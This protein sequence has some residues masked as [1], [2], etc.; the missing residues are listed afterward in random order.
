M[1]L[2]AT[3]KR[4]R[5]D[6][7]G[8]FSSFIQQ[9]STSER[10]DR[11]STPRPHSNKK[12]TQS[13]QISK[14]SHRLQDIAIADNAKAH[15]GNV[16]NKV[17]NN[18]GISYEQNAEDKRWEEFLN[19]LRF[20]SMG[21]RFDAITPAHFDTCQ[22]IF[23]KAEFLRWRN[24]ASGKSRQSILWLKGKPGAGKS[25]LMKCILEHIR[26]SM[27]GYEP[28]SFFFNARGDR[29]ERSVEGMYRSMLCE[30]LEK[31]PHLRTMITIPRAWG[32]GQTLTVESLRTLF[33]QAVLGLKHEQII[34][35]MDALDEGDE[36]EVRSMIEFVTALAK[37]AK[38]QDTPFEICFASRHYP[39][40]SASG[41]EE[42]IV[43]R[44]AEHAK[45]IAQYVRSNLHMD[46]GTR[47]D[48]F[49]HRIEQTAEGVFMWAVLIV[50]MLNRESD[51]G[52]SNSDLMAT[53][54]ETPTDLYEVL[55]SIFQSG[56]SDKN[57]LPVLVWVFTRR[58]LP[59]PLRVEELYFGVQ[60][61][62][63]RLDSPFWNREDVNEADMKRFILSA[64]KGLVEVVTSSKWDLPDIRF[65]HESVRDHILAGGLGFVCP[66]LQ[67]HVSASSH[68][69]AAKWC[70]NYLRAFDGCFDDPKIDYRRRVVLGDMSLVD[71]VLKT[72]LEHLQIAF[73]GGV[74][75][76]ITLHE[77]PLKQWIK[78]YNLCGSRN[79]EPPL[80]PSAT[81]LYLLLTN[82]C[83]RLAK[84]L[85]QTC[86]AWLDRHDE[87]GATS[88]KPKFLHALIGESLDE[89]CGGDLEYP[90]L[91]AICWAKQ[92]KKD[93]VRLMLNRGADANLQGGR[94]KRCA[95]SIS[96]A[97]GHYE[98]VELL[99]DHGAEIDS[100]DNLF[101]SPLLAA[102]T[103]LRY[104]VAALLLDRGA[105]IYDSA[106]A[107]KE[108][109]RSGGIAN[110][111]DKA[112]FVQLLLDRS[113]SGRNNLSRPLLLAAR[114]GE[115]EVVPMLLTSGAD[116]NARDEDLRTALHL[117]Q[118]REVMHL[119]Q[120]P[121]MVRILLE[122]GANVNA[123]G[124]EYETA[125]IAASAKGYETHVQVLLEFGADVRHRSATHGTAA[126]AAQAGYSKWS[127][128]RD[129]IYASAL[130][131]HY[132]RVIRL[133]S[134]A[135]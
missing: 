69:M 32:K 47:K 107:V 55:R 14:G 122:H 70:L 60:F 98:I 6:S 105:R 29:L 48:D 28:I 75:E 109:I 132:K 85:L 121:A 20:E 114:R 91:A 8:A 12:E 50:T 86:S 33:R 35:L 11:V 135:T 24:P 123:V 99:L 72:T 82:S 77:F 46:T 103:N 36:N 104:E 97:I 76:T 3:H 94:P 92:Y 133:L 127:S 31:V 84:G 64:S 25:T 4:R 134:E 51:H 111:P 117:A 67:S 119:D 5:S 10:D 65:I 81:L 125:L 62:V 83:A 101:P 17:I 110:S 68:K 131:G 71:Y 41:C 126:Q 115:P 26:G 9:E 108:A 34:F 80:R 128:R 113:V 124:G 93:L 66:P 16:Y 15:L 116:P 102:V 73:E 53:L 45:D 95:L 27:P 78:I 19:A 30:V 39:A 74:L 100:A 52:A 44:Q 42:L 18:Y 57:F 23:K 112:T 63:G 58:A 59:R 130:A 21:S 87:L 106:L 129:S 37:T 90:L 56:V 89:P 1:D 61:S 22:W 49:V 43:E 38:D 2:E 120:V 96:A 7:A 88:A 79:K 40:I 54:K 13:S 118:E